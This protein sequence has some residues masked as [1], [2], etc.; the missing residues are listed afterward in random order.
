MIENRL[1]ILENLEYEINMFQNTKRNAHIF[2]TDQGL[3]L[4]TRPPSEPI[5]LPESAYT[6]PTSY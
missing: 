6:K 4:P 5:C 2:Q 1:T 3:L